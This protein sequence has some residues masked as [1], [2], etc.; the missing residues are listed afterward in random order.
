MAGMTGKTLLA[1][2]KGLLK[3]AGDNVAIP[4]GSPGVNIVDGEETATALYLTDGEV[5]IGTATPGEK[6][7][8]YANGAD[9]AIK[10]HADAGDAAGLHLSSGA[11]DWQL[12]CD[13]GT[14]ENTLAFKCEAVEK[15][16]IQ[17]DGKVGIGTAE[18]TN[19]LHIE[20][21]GAATAAMNILRLTNSGNAASMTNTRTSILFHQY[22]YDGSPA[23][24]AAAKL[25]VGTEGNWTSDSATHDSYMAF[26]T[27]L[28]STVGERMR[29]T[30]AGN[31]GIGTTSPEATLHVKDDSIAGTVIIESDSTNTDNTAPELILRRSNTTN[32]D[33]NDDIGQIRFKAYD[34]ASSQALFSYAGIRT[35][36]TNFTD[37]SEEGSLQF[38][39]AVGGATS[40][41]Q[42]ALT[43]D[44]VGI[45]TTSPSRQLEIAG[46]SAGIEISR[47]DAT[48]SNFP[49]LDFRKSG[50][51]DVG[52][53]TVVVSGESL[54]RIRFYGSSDSGSVGFAQA[55]Y[56]G[57]FASGT[58]NGGDVPGELRFATTADL[59][60]NATPTVRM[61]IDDAGK[62]G[63]G[64][65][66][67][68][69]MLD[70]GD[71][72]VDQDTYIQIACD[73]DNYAGINLKEETSTLFFIR[74]N[75]SDN[76]LYITDYSGDGAILTQDE[77]SAWDW[78][79][80]I[81]LKTDISVIPDALSKV[82]QI[83]GVNYK[84]KK[85][86]SGSSNL[87]PIADA[88]TGLTSD[89]KEGWTEE[90]W[91]DLRARRDRKNIGVIAQ[92]VNEVL[93]ELVNKDVDGKWTVK[94]EL[95]IPLLIEAVKELSAKVTAL[96][97]A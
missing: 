83:R 30:S 53:H 94:R 28:N 4:T 39:T 49:T 88:E 43:G 23:T 26:L 25:T 93:P 59:G 58:I 13:A 34:N 19:L 82:N 76:K 42:M 84:W 17:A 68:G 71:V 22:Y 89:G 77:T 10:I 87:F 46:A 5:G 62:V 54:G 9:V 61:T 90:Y 64:T 31:V 27:S 63:I 80:D 35:V 86:K 74:L 65:T 12:I 3:T 7:E 16:T 96:E 70:I 60:T 66:S 14:S 15:V 6:L 24:E 20:K 55:A 72:T 2:Y 32:L 45:G 81:N 75:G 37:G 38:Q 69:A 44:K 1:T 18:P 21:A 73:T 52:S 40:S 51:T 57:A 50:H 56:I 85:Y 91:E 48:N 78:S 97:N 41:T 92:E 79:S 29:I 95:L 47:Y 11:I 67:P 8:V 33:N 36:I